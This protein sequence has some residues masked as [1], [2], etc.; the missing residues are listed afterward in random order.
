M[1]RIMYLMCVFY[2]NEF[3]RLRYLR[4]TAASTVYKCCS[5]KFPCLVYLT[6]QSGRGRLLLVYRTVQSGRGRL[7]LV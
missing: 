2:V 5:L 1:N 4:V 6:V 3:F 7:L